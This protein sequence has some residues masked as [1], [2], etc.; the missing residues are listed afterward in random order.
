M[1]MVWLVTLSLISFVSICWY[2]F[3]PF[4]YA[5]ITRSRQFTQDINP[6]EPANTLSS[7]VTTTL[8]YCSLWWGPLIDL[9]IIIWALMSAQK[10]DI[11]SEYYG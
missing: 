3:Q 4:S 2:I 10:R 1:F 9:I 11:E 7:V 5:I 6:E 8:L